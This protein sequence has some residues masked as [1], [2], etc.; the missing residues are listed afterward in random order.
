MDWETT[1]Y[2]ER[3]KFTE[4]F[5]W[6]IIGDLNISTC[7]WH[8][9]YGLCYETIVWHITRLDN[10]KLERGKYKH[11]IYHN[12]RTE[13]EHIHNCLIRHYLKK[14]GITVSR[15]TLEKDWNGGKIKEKTND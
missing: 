10:G 15:Y 12:N 4:N 13:A 1:D 5:D 14:Q 9:G 11:W 7:Q 3:Q 6:A 8:N 2:E